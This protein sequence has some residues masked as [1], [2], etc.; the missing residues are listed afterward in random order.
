MDEWVSKTNAQ[1][2]KYSLSL[3]NQNLIFIQISTEHETALLLVTY[4][5]VGLSLV[6]LMLTLIS[7]AILR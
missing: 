4:V 5:G 2:L 1:V 6:A 3:H 7:F